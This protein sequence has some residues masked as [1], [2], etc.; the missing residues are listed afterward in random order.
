MILI[1]IH[2]IS[3]IIQFGKKIYFDEFFKKISSL[4][5]TLFPLCSIEL[6]TFFEMISTKYLIRFLCYLFFIDFNISLVTLTRIYIIF[7]KITI[8]EVNWVRRLKSASPD[9]IMTVLPSSQNA[10]THVAGDRLWQ[11]LLSLPIKKKK[12][13]V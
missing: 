12:H 2:H 10:G 11:R 5:R 7:M 8:L 6:Q 13:G 9:T 1:P 3:V 4:K